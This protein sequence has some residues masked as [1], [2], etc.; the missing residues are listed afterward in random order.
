MTPLTIL[1]AFA[2]VAILPQ[3]VRRGVEAYKNVRRGA[4]LPETWGASVCALVG[5]GITAVYFGLPSGLLGKWHPL[6]VFTGVN[7]MLFGAVS[8]WRYKQKY[9]RNGP[10]VREYRP[11]N[12]KQEANR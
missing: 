9:S 7:L 4:R 5:L 2:V 6:L 1:A 8:Q 11:K 10:E 12:W 3:L